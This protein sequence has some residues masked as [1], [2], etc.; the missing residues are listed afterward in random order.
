MPIDPIALDRLTRL[1]GEEL[2]ARIDTAGPTLFTPA[3][4]DDRLMDWSMRDDAIKLQLFRFIDALPL[5]HKPDDVS[6]HLK[7][8][9]AEAGANGSPLIRSLV[10]WLPKRGGGAKFLST[11]AFRGADRMARRFIAGATLEET[12]RAIAAQRKKKLAFTIDLLGEASL[13]EVEAERYKAEY[14]RLVEGL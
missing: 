4:W 7:E 8:Y 6:R 13:T 9:F 14:L 10:R 2:F 12:L 3:W 1:Y 5:L 11:S